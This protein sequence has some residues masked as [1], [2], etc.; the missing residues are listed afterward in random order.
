VRLLG[1]PEGGLEEL[2]RE[3]EEVLVGV[4]DLEVEV[5]GAEEITLL[6]EKGVL[7]FV[8]ALG[9]V[10]DVLTVGKVLRIVR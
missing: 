3:I 10:R 1:D 6:G 4:L 5:E 9:G 7:F 2:L 8:V